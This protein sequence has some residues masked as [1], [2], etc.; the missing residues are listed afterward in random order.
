MNA[1][2][3]TH[4]AHS[5]ESAPVIVVTGATGNIGRRLVD[6]LLADGAAVRALTRDPARAA[7]PAGAETVRA[8]LTGA[9]DLAPL[10]AGADALY[11]NLAAGGE[12]AVTALVDAAVA[13]GV[14]RIV[15]NSSMAVTGTPADDTNHI[16]RMHAAA[17]RTVRASG[18]E[19]TFVRGSNYSANTLAWAPSIRASGVV[20]DAHPGAQGSPVHEADLADVAAVALLDRGGAHQGQAY[21]VTGPE[22][23][24]IAQ[25]VA[26]IG[27][28]TGRETRVEQISEEAAAEAMAGPHFP[29]EAARQL[30]ALFGTMVDAPTFPVSDA[31]PRVT[32]HPG[33]TYAEWARDHAAD[34]S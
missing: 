27:R 34:F 5:P 22:V 8:D 26:E 14:R 13:A 20:R 1:A 33:R 32:G 4:P 15:L 7:L 12:Q 17:E 18:L 21:L 28:A 9:Q 2:N 3:P 11:L 30:V 19:W 24:T 25:Q 31:V 29:L 10:L 6:H 23:L 16:A